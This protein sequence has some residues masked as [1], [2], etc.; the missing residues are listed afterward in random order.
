MYASKGEFK[1]NIRR[2]EKYF[3]FT[4]MRQWH[5]QRG[6]SSSFCPNSIK[7][8]RKKISTRARGV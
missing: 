3:Y 1:M 2:R 4:K 8:Q 5:T 6:L 7:K